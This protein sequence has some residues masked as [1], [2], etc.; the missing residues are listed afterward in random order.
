M[1][2]R[3]TEHIAVFVFVENLDRGHPSFGGISF[4][5]QQNFLQD[6]GDERKEETR[7]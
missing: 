5:K 2:D 4:I 1:A 6:K 7:K 3:P